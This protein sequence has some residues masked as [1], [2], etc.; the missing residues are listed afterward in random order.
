MN[1]QFK[2]RKQEVQEKAAD[3]TAQLQGLN[4]TAAEIE[5]RRTEVAIKGKAANTERMAILEGLV[6]GTKSQSQ[7][8]QAV[9]VC[10]QIQGEESSLSNMLN[11]I[12]NQQEQVGS[13]LTQT[14]NAVRDYEEAMFK[15]IYADRL[16]DLRKK[17]GDDIIELYALINLC[18]MSRIPDHVFYS[19]VTGD[20]VNSQSTQWAKVEKMMNDLKRKHIG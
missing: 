1:E 4:K 17:A 2:K 12:G 18:G 14:R 20:V 5:K 15:S 7:Y 13:A 9:K 16:Q 8:D 11:D 3:L 19:D 10:D 6:M